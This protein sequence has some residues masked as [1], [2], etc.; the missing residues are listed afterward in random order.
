[1][2][3]LVLPIRVS[4][5]WLRRKLVS[6]A[7]FNTFMFRALLNAQPEEVP[8]AKGND[9]KKAVKKAPAKTLKEKRKAKNAKPTD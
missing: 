8:M 4:L 7:R 2:D 6:D 3:V 1:M 9:T 5:A